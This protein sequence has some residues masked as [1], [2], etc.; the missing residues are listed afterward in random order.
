M[1]AEHIVLIYPGL[2]DDFEKVEDY[3]KDIDCEGL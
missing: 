3:I 2:G 1:P